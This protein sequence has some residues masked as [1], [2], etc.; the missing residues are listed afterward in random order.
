MKDGLYHKDLGNL[1][2]VSYSGKLTYTDH[3]KRASMS[4]RYGFINLP[5]RVSPAAK[6]IEV[7][8]KGGRA[9]KAVFRTA[10]DLKHDLCLVV[11]LASGTV[12]TVWLNKLTDSHKTLDKSRYV[13]G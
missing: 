10:Y 8:V 1:P 5:D 9:H 2:A 3:A 4:D 7:E 11:L 13:I 12:K 6:V